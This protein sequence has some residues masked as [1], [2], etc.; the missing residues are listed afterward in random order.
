M[1]VI[2]IETVD[3]EVLETADGPYD[4]YNESSEA[5]NKAYLATNVKEAWLYERS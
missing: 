2:F 1:Y 5:L 4:D 3:G